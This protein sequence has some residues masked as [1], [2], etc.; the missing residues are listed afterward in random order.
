MRYRIILAISTLFLGQ[1]SAEV[2]NL[3]CIN[4]RDGSS[5]SYIIDT[6]TSQVTS[7]STGISTKALINED[8]IYFNEKYPNTQDTF[9][10]NINRITGIMRISFP[11]Q[12]PNPNDPPYVCSKSQ[13]IF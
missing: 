11:G 9:A 10:I 7:K 13:A 6:S 8:I 4:Q 3:S 1:A 2:L 12:P 5:Y